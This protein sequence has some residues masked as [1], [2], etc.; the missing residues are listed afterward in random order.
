VP[1]G[2]WCYF[3]F[4]EKIIL[5][6]KM[7]FLDRAFLKAKKYFFEGLNIVTKGDD[8]VPILEG[9]LLMLLVLLIFHRCFGTGT[10]PVIPKI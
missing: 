1:I 4:F 3:C 2:I 5:G 6:L 9:V 8:L 7:A 10:Q